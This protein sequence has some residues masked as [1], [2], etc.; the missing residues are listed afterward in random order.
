M[1]FNHM[2]D[3]HPSYQLYNCPESLPTPS[4]PT[5][6][7]HSP[8]VRITSEVETV[9]QEDRLVIEEHDRG[10]VLR[11]RVRFFDRLDSAVFDVPEKNKKEL[12][13]KKKSL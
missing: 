3:Q 9:G 10:A 1:T 6:S 13:Y 11:D 5:Q 2:V 12:T 7:P 8:T 4:L